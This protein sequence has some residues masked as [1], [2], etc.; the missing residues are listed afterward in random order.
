[1]KPHEYYINVYGIIDQ[2]QRI[3]ADRILY[4]SLS[5]WSSVFSDI[6][7]FSGSVILNPG[8]DHLF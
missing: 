1:M 3:I 5:F 2:G 6:F 8:A 4:A 7:P